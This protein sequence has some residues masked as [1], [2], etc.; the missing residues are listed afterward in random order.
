MKSRAWLIRSRGV[1]RTRH[2]SGPPT[3]IG[4]RTVALDPSRRPFAG[5]GPGARLKAASPGPLSLLDHPGEA[6]AGAILEPDG[7]GEGAAVLSRPRRVVSIPTADVGE[8]RHRRL[9]DRA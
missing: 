5:G 8:R 6:G 7:V 3:A 2:A 1:A 4:R 9:D